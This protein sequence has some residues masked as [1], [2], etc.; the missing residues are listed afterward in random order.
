MCSEMANM[1]TSHLPSKRLG[2]FYSVKHNIMKQNIDVSMFPRN[3]LVTVCLKFSS[4]H[5]PL[6][7]RVGG[8]ITDVSWYA[9]YR[10][11]PSALSRSTLYTCIPFGAS[12]T[13][14]SGDWLRKKEDQV[15]KS[16]AIV[17]YCLSRC[18]HF[19]RTGCDISSVNSLPRQRLV[20]PITLWEQKKPLP[21]LTLK[22]FTSNASQHV[23]VPRFMQA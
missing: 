10:S 17:R 13:D 4:H 15:H 9:M 5:V 7:W 21:H 6:F 12:T 3:H 2:S 14:G 8:L 23:L 22:S 18:Q 11:P 16:V 19:A 20:D 1:G